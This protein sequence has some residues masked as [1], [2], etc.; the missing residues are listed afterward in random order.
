VRA[1]SKAGNT[2]NCNSFINGTEALIAAASKKATKSVVD[3]AAAAKTAADAK[4]GMKDAS[5][6]KFWADWKRYY[7]NCNSGNTTIERISDYCGF[8]G[9]TAASFTNVSGAGLVGLTEALKTATAACT[10]AVCTVNYSS[11]KLPRTN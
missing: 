1:L 10:G 6:N 9:A 2:S 7:D 11:V 4:A 5:N 3:V 8:S